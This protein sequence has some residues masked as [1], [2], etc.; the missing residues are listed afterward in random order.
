[1]RLFKE[2]IR[3]KERRDLSKALVGVFESIRRARARATGAS[4]LA[5]T[6]TLRHS[7]SGRSSIQTRR[8][9]AQAHLGASARYTIRIAAAAATRGR[10][11]IA[12]SIGRGRCRRGRG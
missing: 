10:R 2:M 8:L 1:M 11:R 7:L 5:A 12:S 3:V 9:C 6:A 4:A